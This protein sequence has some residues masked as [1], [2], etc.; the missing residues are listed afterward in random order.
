MY[1]EF[2]NN[3]ESA[4]RFDADAT[5]IAKYLNK[6]P[7]QLTCLWEEVGFGIFCNGLFR[8]INPENYQP[9]VDEYFASKDDNYRIPFM[10]TAYG[11]LFVWINNTRHIGN[12][13]LYINMRYGTYQFLGDESSFEPILNF[14]VFEPDTIDDYFR[15]KGYNRIR[16]NMGVPAMDE[17]FAYVPALVLG[18]KEADK[19]IQIVKILPYI[20]IIAQMTSFRMIE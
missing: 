8:I 18:G 16:E 19:N 4:L 1:E 7:N 3:N 14:L 15:L 9:F 11:D 17:C 10:I 2:L 20:E 5:I 12:H 13:I 6:A